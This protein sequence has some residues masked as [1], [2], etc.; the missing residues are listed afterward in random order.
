M[1]IGLLEIV[2]SLFLVPLLVTVL[3]LVLAAIPS[4]VF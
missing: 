4:C 2:L 3:I 1:K